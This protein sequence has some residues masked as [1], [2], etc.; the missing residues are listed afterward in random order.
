MS[1]RR[2]FACIALAVLAGGATAHAVCSADQIIGPEPGCS[3]TVVAC[4]VAGDYV[5]DNGCTLDFG[6]HE[7]TLTEASHLEIGS[8]MAT[9]RAA[10][11][12]VD[13]FIDGVG[14]ATGAR[15]GLLVIE[16]S[17]PFSVPAA[18]KIDMSGNRNG[19]QV[20][21]RAGGAVSI[22]GKVRVDDLNKAAG[23]G[24]IDISAGGNLASSGTISAQGGSDSDGGGEIDLSA[25]GNLTLSSDLDVSGLDGGFV[26]L[27]AGGVLNMHGIAASGGGDAGSGG[28]ID[29]TAGAGATVSGSIISNGAS[30][31]FMTG[32]CGGLICVDAGF[33]NFT[34][35]DGAIISSDGASPDGGGGNITVV[36]RG[37]AII[38]G[39]LSARGPAG[40]TCGGCLCV[41]TGFDTTVA[42]TGSLDVSAGD[43]GGGVT[44]LVG[45][46]AVI[47]GAIDAS[48]QRPGSLGGDVSVRAGWLGS[49]NLTVNSTID[50]SS[51]GS[52]SADDGCGEGGT[53]DLDGCNVTIGAGATLLATAPDGGEN[54]VTAR[55]LL[56]VQGVLDARRTVATGTQGT[57]HS[58]FPVRRPPMT[59]NATFQPAV[60]GVGVATCPN[61]STTV[62]TCLTPCPVCGDGLVQFP[63][64]CDKGVIPPQSCAG[65]SVYCQ[66]ESCDDGLIC[67]IDS[68]LPAYGCMNIVST[69][70]CSE[71][72]ATVTGTPPT[73]TA[74]QTRTATRTATASA[75]F[76]GT[77]TQTP[78][79]GDTP[80]A[81]S[82]PTASLTAT[83]TATT[84]V[85][86]TSSATPSPTPQATSTVSAT[87][88]TTG[89]ATATAS[90][91]ATASPTGSATHT[92][93]AT[94]T[95]SPPCPGDCG[96]DG[97]V[98]VN[99]LI[100]G[101]NIA[102]GNDGIDA[103]PA[104]D[105]DGDG[106]VSISELIAGVNAALTHC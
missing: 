82:S 42:S 5:I 100:I 55:E 20:L 9:I 103:C 72:T 8:N 36:T 34:L 65:C 26:E 105:R 69:P 93:T 39:L 97:E 37:N 7:V 67:T 64:T 15:G 1:L 2:T 28:C 101:V 83:R 3:P 89:T 79:L 14:N 73:G 19:G 40:E 70:G 87:A 33:G 66:A 98:A 21:V 71:P 27:R 50:V 90:P 68:C 94:Q 48:S 102:L 54:D 95:A 13:G 96:G 11:L 10:R 76:T 92:A 16:T 57:N 47:N 60:R 59:Q 18:G 75:S 43:S 17:G 51:S 46:H 53:T 91:S 63:E 81:S 32:G 86:P 56:T 35:T 106:Q 99:E 31:T 77:P 84:A 45:R 12:T 49:G 25:G 24:L 61:Q 58:V 41:E 52:C 88:S 23:G 74:T 4:T 29:I 104:F 80:T 38:N 78:T 30:G 62:P 85:S 22:A 6:T 44:M